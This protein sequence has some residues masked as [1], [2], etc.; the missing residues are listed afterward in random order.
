MNMW[1]TI[2]DIR[3]PGRP[4][5]VLR[6]WTCPICKTEK[7]ARLV[8]YGSNLPEIDDSDDEDEEPSDD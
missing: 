3:T 5:E 4:P 7:P 8:E 2:Y 6:I 1:T